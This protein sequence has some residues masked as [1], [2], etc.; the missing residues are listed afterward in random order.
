MMPD[1]LLWFY[2]Y[3]PGSDLDETASPST[4]MLSVTKP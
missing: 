3:Y 2:L 4:G 1:R